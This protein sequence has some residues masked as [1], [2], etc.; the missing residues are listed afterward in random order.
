MTADPDSG[1]VVSRT[2]V[3]LRHAKAAWPEG[4]ADL[5]RPLAERGQEQAPLAGRW[6]RETVAE[7]ELVV[8]S[9]A[10][11]TRQTAERVLAVLDVEPELVFDDRLYDQPVGRL[12]KVMTEIP[13]PVAVAMFV[14]HNPQ[15]SQLAT[16]LSGTSI[17]F[18][19]SSIAVVSFDGTWEAFGSLEPGAAQLRAFVTP[20]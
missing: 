10:L 6:L 16:Y 12:L 1:T 14:G 8:C 18:K 19:T 20:R 15:V 7:I 11:R 17:E 3:L 9:P 2:L 13:D 5:S 4:V